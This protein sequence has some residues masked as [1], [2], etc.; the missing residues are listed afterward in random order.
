MRTF[1]FSAVAGAIVLTSTA[2]GLS[3][4]ANAASRHRQQRTYA[5]PTTYTAPYVRQDPSAAFN[6]LGAP[7]LPTH[8]QRDANPISGTPR[9]N[10]LGSAP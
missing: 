4:D 2:I 9:W 6:T 10:Y 1:L 7:S 3:S 8:V 5:A